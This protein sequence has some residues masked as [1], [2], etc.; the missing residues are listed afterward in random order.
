MNVMM[1]AVRSLWRGHYSLSMSVSVAFHYIILKDSCLL[2]HK[3]V[4]L[5]PIGVTAIN[6]F[7]RIGCHI[8]CSGKSVLK[9]MKWSGSRRLKRSSCCLKDME[10]G[11]NWCDRFKM[12]FIGSMY[13]LCYCDWNTHSGNITAWHTSTRAARKIS[14]FLTWGLLCLMQHSHTTSAQI[15]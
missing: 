8:K 2:Q 3:Y 7:L 15:V 1:Q 11:R 4:P 5:T 12:F 9:W 10:D 6:A 13:C 14:P